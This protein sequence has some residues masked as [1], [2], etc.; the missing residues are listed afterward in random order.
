MGIVMSEDAATIIEA[1]YVPE[2]SMFLSFDDGVSGTWPFDRLGLDMSDMV[3]DTVRAVDG[4]VQ[5]ISKPGD[6]VVL[7][8]LTFRYLI[9]PAYAAKVDAELN[10][11]LIPSER[12][13]RVAANNQ[14]PQAWYDSVE[15]DK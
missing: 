1:R 2:S 14:P 8:A 15:D 5:V 7:D 9:D 11:L 10:S 4:D 13:E 12:L 3:V 6:P